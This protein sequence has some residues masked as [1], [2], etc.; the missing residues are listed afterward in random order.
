MDVKNK[1][2]EEAEDEIVEETI[3]SE[4][5]HILSLKL[6][7]LVRN[8]QSKH[9]LRHGDYQRYRGY[10]SRRLARL[11]KVLKLVQVRN[12]MMYH[13]LNNIFMRRF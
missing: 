10:C 13:I 11:R 1:E 12:T 9:G 3:T 5:F 4:G 2:N 6:L 8:L 7:P